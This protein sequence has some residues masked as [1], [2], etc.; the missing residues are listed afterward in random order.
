MTKKTPTKKPKLPTIWVRFSGGRDGHSVYLKRPWYWGNVHRYAPVQPPKVC[1]WTQR[2]VGNGQDIWHMCEGEWYGDD[3][4]T[5]C[6]ECGGRIK[7]K[8]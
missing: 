4:Y 1:V 3:P 7:V 6:P 5:Y 2:A 8:S